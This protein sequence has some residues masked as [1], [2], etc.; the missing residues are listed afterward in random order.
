M[1]AA[2]RLAGAALLL[3]LLLHSAVAAS[4]AKSNVWVFLTDGAFPRSSH[5]QQQQPLAEARAR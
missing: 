4:A 1:A 5:S 2:P 3:A